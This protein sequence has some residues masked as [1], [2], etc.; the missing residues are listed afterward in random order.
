MSVQTGISP[1]SMFSDAGSLKQAT[2][3]LFPSQNLA[4]ATNEGNPFP[5]RWLT[6]HHG[7]HNMMLVMSLKN[8]SQSKTITRQYIK[9]LMILTYTL[10][11]VS[12]SHSVVSNSEQSM[13]FS[14]PE[15]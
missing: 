3:E 6:V 8:V 2:E 4:S 12:E 7:I 15:Y 1:H 13:E 11:Y 9:M 14:R 10:P 5:G